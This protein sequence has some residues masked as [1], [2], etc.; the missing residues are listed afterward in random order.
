MIR[1]HVEGRFEDLK[2]L[3]DGGSV[4]KGLEDALF[5]AVEGERTAGFP[6]PNV[7]RLCRYPCRV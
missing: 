6:K 4:T 3:K 7:C 5:D 2:L 1:R